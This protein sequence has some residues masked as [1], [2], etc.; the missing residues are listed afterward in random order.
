MRKL[1]DVG[2]RIHELIR[3]RSAKVEAAVAEVE[4]HAEKVDDQPL[5]IPIQRAP[6]RHE[7]R[8]LRAAQRRSGKK[9]RST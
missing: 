9:A 5:R 2:A 7:R 4:A 3:Q 6:N 8:A 1:S